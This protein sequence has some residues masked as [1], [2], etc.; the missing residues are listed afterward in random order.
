MTGKKKVKKLQKKK[1]IE[2]S[3][4]DKKRKT[5][6]LYT[7]IVLLMLGS[8]SVIGG[9]A[10]ALDYVHQK[11]VS[12]IVEIVKIIHES[13][14]S[15]KHSA[16]VQ[17]LL[18]SSPNTGRYEKQMNFRLLGAKDFGVIPYEIMSLDGKIPGK[19]GP[20]NI[21]S[22]SLTNKSDT[23]GITLSYLPEN[24]CVELIKKEYKNFYQVRT[25]YSAE[26]MNLLWSS[27][28]AFDEDALAIKCEQI[29]KSGVIQFV[30]EPMRTGQSFEKKKEVVEYKA[31][32]EQS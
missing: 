10:F 8:F 25:G 2:Q 9:T 6:Q 21:Y 11:E 4:K 5:K 22:L 24:V 3:W 20:V 12:E 31:K 27:G 23:F 7:K 30:L 13:I 16:H 15:V 26:N 32:L 29:G 28:K 18:V 17:N 19:Y 1:G 14:N